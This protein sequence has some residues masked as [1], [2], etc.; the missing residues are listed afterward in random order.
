MASIHSTHARHS[1]KDNPAFKMSGM[2][3]TFIAGSMLCRNRFV[4]GW[5]F[6]SIKL[7]TSLRIQNGI[8]SWKKALV[9]KLCRK[10]YE[11]EFKFQK[12][13]QR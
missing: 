8:E 6:G 11:I 1:A 4:R 9:V 12:R 3:R 2:L 5:K 7:D 13:I 10:F